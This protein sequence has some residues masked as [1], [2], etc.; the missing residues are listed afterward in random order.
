MERGEL[1]IEK[2]GGVR[3]LSTEGRVSRGSQVSERDRM[4]SLRSDIASWREVG[5]SSSGVTDEADVIL[6]WER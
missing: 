1:R 4:S 3:L 5:L 6:R 2:L